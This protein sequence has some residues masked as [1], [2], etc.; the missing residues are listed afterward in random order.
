[1]LVLSRKPEQT[2]LLGADIAVTVLSIDGDRVKLGINAP[3][4][5]AVLRQEIFDQVQAAN[6]AA[7][8]ASERPSLESIATALKTR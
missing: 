6:A 4:H 3:R 1:V 5:V 7:A 8:R 2:L